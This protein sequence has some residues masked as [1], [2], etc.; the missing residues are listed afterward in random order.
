MME[1][2]A[3]PIS[4]VG[5]ETFDSKGFLDRYFEISSRGSSQRQEII[6]GVT[7]FLAMVYSVFVV[8]GMFGKAGFDTSAVFV[9]V[10][11]TTAFG[12]L[13]MGVWEVGRLVQVEQLLNNAAREGARQ[14]ST[15]NVTT[16]GV[17]CEPA[18]TVAGVIWNIAAITISAMR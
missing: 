1:P 8:P 17:P 6:A 13:L 5:V 11:L 4:E 10:C 15:S 9:A 16:A 14:A 3:Q 2:T 18:I 7:T 12:S